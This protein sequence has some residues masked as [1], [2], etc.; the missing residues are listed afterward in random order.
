ML[1]AALSCGVALAESEHP[2][3]ARLG[4]CIE[5]DSS[6]AG[7]IQ[8][9]D[10]AAKEWDAELNRVYKE[11]MKKLPK[12]SAESLKAAQ[13]A[14]LKHRDAENSFLGDLYGQFDGTM[15]RP[16]AVDAV[17]EVTRRRA[18]VLKRYLDLLTEEQPQDK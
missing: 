4:K 3:E 10:A 9:E 16:M 17:K 8:C 11:L 15:Y 2:I 12:K 14:W 13:V 18:E 1:A 5:K 7:M 6:T